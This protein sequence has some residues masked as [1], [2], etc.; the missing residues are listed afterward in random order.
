[1]ELIESKTIEAKHSC[2]TVNELLHISG[3]MCEFDEAMT[4]NDIERARKTLESVE[5]SPIFITPIL[6]GLDLPG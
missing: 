1:M 4:E 3:F 5:L 2:V 6:E